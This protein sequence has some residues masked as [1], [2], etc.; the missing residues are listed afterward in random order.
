MVGR[1]FAVLMIGIVAAALAASI[2]AGLQR[3][4]DVSAERQDRVIDRVLTQI[5][6]GEAIPGLHRLQAWPKGT[7]EDRLARRLAA[8]APEW[9]NIAAASVPAPDCA[10]PP[11][12]PMPLGSLPPVP[13]PPPSHCYAVRLVDPQG[14]SVLLAVDAPPTPSLVDD[15]FSWAFIAALCVAALLLALVIARM[16]A[17]PMTR[18]GLAAQQLATDLG[19]DPIVAR[20]PSEV[21]R[22]I[23]AFNDMQVELRRAMEERTYMLAAISHDLRS[24]LTRMRLRFD[25]IQD[26]T[27]RDK[28][29][30]DAWI[31]DGLIEEGLDL[32]RL[33]RS[34]E[35]FERVD[36]RALVTS[37]CEDAQDVGQPV[38]FSTLP[39]MIVRTR[40][41]ALRRILT[42]LVEN[43][44]AYGNEADLSATIAADSVSIEVRD[45]GPGIAAE[46]LTKVFEPFHRVD[47][48]RAPAG[49]TGL[50]LTIARLLAQK[51]GGSISLKNRA[52][53][54]LS[55]TV[56]V[57]LTSS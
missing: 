2:L 16:A 54:G 28:L 14:N 32:A 49:G 43:A 33:S 36:I 1:I 55:A 41:E 51:I 53:G 15:S 21:R 42:N 52:G 8:R 46:A 10:P 37:L 25:A 48:A 29:I 20:G 6:T 12:A 7:P 56:T 35:P 13:P 47:G 4:S 44:L 22:T 30:E 17:R 19:A 23:E 24:P 18:L 5:S 40:P 45:T 27:L 34:V 3:R 38:R 9:R 26:A 50:G 11:P 57:P 39:P 31:M